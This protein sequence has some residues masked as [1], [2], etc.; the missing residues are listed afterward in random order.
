[1]FFVC[2]VVLLIAHGSASGACT[3]PAEK[4]CGAICIPK[5]MQ[6]CTDTNLNLPFACRGACGESF[7]RC[8]CAA[9]QGCLGCSAKLACPSGSKCLTLGADTNSFC[10]VECPSGHTCPALSTCITKPGGGEACC[11]LTINKLCGTTC[12]SG[13]SVCCDPATGVACDFTTHVCGKS[14]E[15][16]CVLKDSSNSCAMGRGR[17]TRTAAPWLLPGLL[18]I[19]WRCRRRLLGR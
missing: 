2:A 4:A 5:D 1:M 16:P 11:D 14:G 10:Y 12:I 18:L 15:D 3:D 8:E 19:G 7:Q 13:T 9:G 6:C 17:A